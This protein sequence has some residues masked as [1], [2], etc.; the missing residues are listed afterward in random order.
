MKVGATE[1]L[2]PSVTP[3]DATDK[4]GKWTTDK[5]AIATVDA[6]GKVTAV[7]EG[8]ANITFTTTD[9]GFTAKCTVTVT[10]A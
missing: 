6:N 1:T 8:T 5:T 9:G 4:T 2:T 10:A 7:A 3:S